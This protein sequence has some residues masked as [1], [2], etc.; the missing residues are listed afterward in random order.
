MDRKS[1]LRWPAFVQLFLLV[2][3]T[4][5][6]LLFFGNIGG[7]TDLLAF[8]GDAMIIFSFATSVLGFIAY[9]TGFS[10]NTPQQRI[11]LACLFLLHL[12]IASYS[13]YITIGTLV[14]RC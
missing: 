14:A 6:L 1:E 13:L 5:Y 4:I 11:L 2:I 12:V 8:H 3:Q 10:R 7:F 9:L